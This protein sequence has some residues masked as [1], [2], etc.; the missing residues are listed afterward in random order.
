MTPDLPR[1]ARGRPR[2]TSRDPVASFT[3]R[4][5]E[6]Q[7]LALSAADRRRTRRALTQPVEWQCEAVGYSCFRLYRLRVSDGMR[8]TIAPVQGGRC[9]VHIGSYDEAVLF[10]A[11]SSG[12]PSA[13]IPLAESAI[14]QADT[15]KTEPVVPKLATPSP[16]LTVLRL[17]QGFLEGALAVE[18]SRL[19]DELLKL[20]T[21]LSE[22]RTELR[23]VA[24]GFEL[25]AEAVE[26]DRTAAA[27]E[28]ITTD[29]RVGRLEAGYRE[30]T[31]VLARV[32]GQFQRLQG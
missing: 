25:Q 28:R 12:P 16:E 8:A 23:D 4:R 29:E 1:A 31:D 32:A 17:L 13:F 22:A 2:R 26:R 10:A 15:L 5:A 3:T 11:R 9:V 20:I 21:Q 6:E 7:F 14:M 18:T 24:A 19:E 30:L 27:A